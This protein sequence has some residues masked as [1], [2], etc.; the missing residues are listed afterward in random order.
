MIPPNLMESM[1]G[2]QLAKEYLGIQVT[3]VNTSSDYDLLIRDISVIDPGT[4]GCGTRTSHTTAPARNTAK[5]VAT[6]EEVRKIVSDEISKSLTARGIRGPEQAKLLA[7][8]VEQD[9]AES[10]GKCAASSHEL[11]NLR[12]AAERGMSQDPRNI[13]L[14]GLRAVGIVGGGLVA[15]AGLGPILPLAVSAFSNSLIPAYEKL[16]PDY[17]IGQMNRLND[18]AYAA[19][20]LV[21]RKRARV[22]TLFIPLQTLLHQSEMSA[23][24][25]DPYPFLDGPGQ[26]GLNGLKIE[27]D[28]THIVALDEI[29]PLVTQVVIL[30]QQARNLLLGQN[31]SGYI[32]GQFLDGADVALSNSEAVGVKV[33]L[34]KTHASTDNRLYFVLKPTAAIPPNT[35][36]DLEVLRAKNK[37]T[38]AFIPDL[39]FEAV[40]LLGVKPVEAATFATG[41]DV[42]AELTGENFYDLRK[43]VTVTPADAAMGSVKVSA[44]TIVTPQK[45]TV[46]IDL[47]NAKAGTWK[48]VVTINGVSS[49]PANFMVE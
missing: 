12:G 47:K 1:F 32:A 21:A 39:P 49:N 27:L 44:V 48:V 17:T 28:F 26:N 23:F 25:K 33:D 14:R 41:T 8:T 43:T 45:M 16:F 30:Q 7:A 29:K 46:A 36:L 31:A 18:S 4:E 24:A 20:T 3:V 35:R 15:V 38:F 10:S 19:N 13:G 34:D 6:P 22:M 37:A 42:K 2:H 11:S 9:R 40:S 5:L